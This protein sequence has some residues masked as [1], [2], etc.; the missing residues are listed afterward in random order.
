MDVIEIQP[1]KKNISVSIN[2]FDKNSL[3]TNE[4]TGFTT[5]P[6]WTIFQEGELFEV[7]KIRR[8][9]IYTRWHSRGVLSY[10]CD[11]IKIKIKQVFL[12]ISTHSGTII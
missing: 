5:K 8:N 7:A 11:R 4:D 6:L 3:G 2:L 12:K 9:S 10:L 1:Q